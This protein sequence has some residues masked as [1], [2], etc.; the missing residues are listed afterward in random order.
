MTFVLSKGQSCGKDRV[1]K[2]IGSVL[3][4]KV[5]RSCEYELDSR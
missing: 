5:V 4:V 1:V 2:R 3:M